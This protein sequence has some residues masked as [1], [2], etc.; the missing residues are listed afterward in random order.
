MQPQKITARELADLIGVSSRRIRE[1]RSD[2]VLPG[3]AGDPYD[4]AES[5][6]SYCRHLRPSSGRAAAG[7]AST[8]TLNEA[9]LGMLAEQTKKLRAENDLL[10]GE[11][12]R[13]SDV[14]LAIGKCASI[15]RGRLLALPTEYA[16]P[17]ARL[18]LPAEV[19]SLLSA[20]VTAALSELQPLLGAYRASA[21]DRTEALAGG[22]IEHGGTDAAT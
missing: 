8:I 9:R 18:R 5:V 22:L 7:G 3:L 20:A 17:L 13:A 4:L 14:T 2:G 19:Q 6:Q 16:A 1:L 21:D 12:L 15:V 10:S 11:T